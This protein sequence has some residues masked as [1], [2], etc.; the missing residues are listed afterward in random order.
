MHPVSISSD[1][2]SKFLDNVKNRIRDSRIRIV[3]S[4]NKEL[5][6]LYWWIGKEISNFSKSHGSK[7]PK[8]V[9]CKYNPGY[10]PKEK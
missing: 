6:Q 7:Q 8:T 4:V 1:Y 5:I 2:Y 10:Y 3:H 9:T